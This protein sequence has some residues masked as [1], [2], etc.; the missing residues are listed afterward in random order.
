[1]RELLLGGLIGL[2]LGIALQMPGWTRRETVQGMFALRSVGALRTL[3]TTL[4]FGCAV[5]AFLMWLAVI[6]VDLLAVPAL[7]GGTVAGGL[8]FGAA[9]A[10]CGH[11]LLTAPAA[12][13]GGRAL[14]G[15]CV[16][17]G[18]LIGAL[19]LPALENAFDAVRGLIP[20]VEGTLFRVT[21]DKPFLLSGDFPALACLGALLLVCALCVRPP[22]P[23]P[24]EPAGARE[25]SAAPGTSAAPQDVRE[26]TFVASLPGEEPV[27][28]DTQEP[29]SP[30]TDEKTGE[31]EPLPD[32][33]DSPPAN[34][35]AGEDEALPDE[36]EPD[37]AP[38]DE[39]EPVMTDHPDLEA[40]PKPEEPG[41]AMLRLAREGG[42]QTPLA[43]EAMP[44]AARLVEP[45][46][47]GD[48]EPSER[49][50]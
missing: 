8:L 41:D 30:P 19:C 28:V 38:S 14:E 39:P 50:G 13:G 37:G 49:K 6:D 17:A 5:T 2:I 20:A 11:T 12:V 36:S 44:A 10:L 21:L 35:K 25:T 26:D 46:R 16:V 45:I 7:D 29:D 3:L 22:R 18:G 34:E 31:S 24:A 40:P 9:A 42:Q 4:G 33:P 48:K 47:E 23:A 15:L 32:E 1:M 43:D 27:V